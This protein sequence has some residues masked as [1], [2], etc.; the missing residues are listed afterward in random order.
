MGGCW[1]P[2]AVQAGDVPEGANP[3]RE[4]VEQKFSLSF[5]TQVSQPEQTFFVLFFNLFIFKFWNDQHAFQV[6]F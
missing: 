4:R 3:E 2:Q 5:L 6:Y 1:D